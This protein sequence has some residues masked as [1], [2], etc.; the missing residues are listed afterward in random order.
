VS[1]FAFTR[2]AGG[3]D[4]PVALVIGAEGRGLAPLSRRRCDVLVSIPQS[5]NIESLNVAAAGAVAFFELARARS[6]T[7]SLS[8]GP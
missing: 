4:R 6:E 8:T 3:F 5:G 1:L 7:L 2:T